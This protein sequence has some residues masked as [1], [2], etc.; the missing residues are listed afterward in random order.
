[1]AELETPP[2]AAP[3]SL[4]DAP[5]GW[6]FAPGSYTFVVAADRVVV[7]QPLSAQFGLTLTPENVAFLDQPGTDR[8]L[9][10]PIE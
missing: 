7:G 2:A 8:F 1:M 5:N 3:L 10:F 4:F 9:T 6:F